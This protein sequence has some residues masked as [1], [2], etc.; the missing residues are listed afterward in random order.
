MTEKSLSRR[1]ILKRGAALIAGTTG[2]AAIRPPLS[3][4]AQSRRGPKN[5]R[6]SL[7]A[8]SFR[9]ALTGGR[10]DLFKFIDWCARIN[11]SGVE[12]TSYYFPEEFD[13]KYL[14]ELKHRVLDKGL[15]V[16][17]TAIR[18]NF[19]LPKGPEKQKEIDHVKRW[20]D[21]AAEFYAP[22][23]R[24]FAGELPDGTDH[25]TGVSWVADGIRECLGHA[26]ERGV[27]LGV[28]NHGHF[29][30]K[31]ED[32]L[33]ICNAVGEHDW[34]G[35]NLDTGNYR[36]NPY[37]S[38]EQA[39]PL[40]V[41]VQYKVE[42]YKSED[43]VKEPADLTRIRDILVKARYQGWIALE[44][45]ADGDPFIAIPDIVNEMKEFFEG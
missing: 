31:V 33:A 14:R 17:G 30:S 28:E 15:T 12:L 8:Y 43:G 23:I 40:A 35:I 11:I 1:G 18:N 34:F 7:A 27:F 19:C 26:E 5:M 38:I 2:L 45:E 16:S 21:Y 9:Q 6:I 39:A 41:N 32:H 20:I 44:Y 25:G 10:M 22:H 4:S 24:I 29:T 3:A 13:R 36:T 37:E 42:V